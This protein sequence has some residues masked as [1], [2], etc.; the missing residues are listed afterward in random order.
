LIDQQACLASL[1]LTPNVL[2]QGARAPF[3]GVALIVKDAFIKMPG[4]TGFGR[5]TGGEHLGAQQL[6]QKISPP[7]Q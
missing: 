3:K 6:L 2:A 7:V 4:S 5:R 1:A